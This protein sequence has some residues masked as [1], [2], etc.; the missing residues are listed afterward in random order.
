MSQ[1]DLGRAQRLPLTLAVAQPHT[2]VGDVGANVAAHI[3]AVS[4][5]GARVVVFPECS[6]TG[7]DFGTQPIDQGDVRLQPLATAA[8][9]CAAVVF[10]GALVR[11]DGE[12]LPSISVLRFCD[13]AVDVAYRKMYLGA[14]EV[15]HVA[16]GPGPA[17]FDVDGWRIGLAIC[18]D[19]GVCAHGDALAQLRVDVCAAG[20]L[21]HL[22][23]AEVQP[24]RARRLAARHGVWVATA[25]YAGSAGEG[26][27]DAAGGS[28]IWSPAGDCLASA[29]LTAGE[30]ATAVLEP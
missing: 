6:L 4:D 14:D 22:H 9:D 11:G 29:G 17:V 8:R 16:P 2:V 30:V 15:G 25:S 23:D 5:A 28:A 21:E 12:T 26:F 18:K 13:G 19:T 7:Y 3:A 20:V 24:G 27:R 1:V 10:A